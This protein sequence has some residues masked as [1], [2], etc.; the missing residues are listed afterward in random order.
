MLEHSLYISVGSIILSLSVVTFFIYSHYQ[1]VISK[2]VYIDDLEKKLHTLEKSISETMD[3]MTLEPLLKKE[4]TKIL[5]VKGAY[6]QMYSESH[7]TGF[8]P[9]VREYFQYFHDERVLENSEETI[10]LIEDE[11]L[12]ERLQQSIPEDI[13]YIFPIF[14]TSGFHIGNIILSE[15]IDSEVYFQDEIEFLK[16]FSFFVEIHLKYIRTYTLMH[17]FSKILDEKV[18]TKTIAYNNLVNR[19]KEFIQV[20]SHEVRSP[21]TSAIFQVESAIENL[22]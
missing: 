16:E 8:F 12:K 5:G 13:A 9:V 1:R 18:D 10:S 21:L 3:I 19:Q 17:E 6:L 2:S 4:L 15:K 22:E 14:S 11:F 7:D 20:I